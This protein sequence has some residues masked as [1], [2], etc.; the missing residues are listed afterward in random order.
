MTKKPVRQKPRQS[1]KEATKLL[2]VGFAGQGVLWLGKRIAEE[3]LRRQPKKFVSFL[4]EYQAG[5]RTGESRA[6]L[7]ISDRPIACPFVGRPDILVELKKGR[8]RC[9]CQVIELKSRG[10]LNEA[11]LK[12]FFQRPECRKLVNS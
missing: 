10:R 6:Q 2:I 12:E 1:N 4:A 5:V 9:G 11:A 8:L 7:I 3:I